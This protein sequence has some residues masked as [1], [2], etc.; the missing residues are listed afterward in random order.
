MAFI[1]LASKSSS[2]RHPPLARWLHLL[3]ITLCLAATGPHARAADFAITGIHTE[4]R[5]GVYVLDADID[6]HF[7]DEALR[8]LSNGVPLTVQ[9]S[10]EIERLRKWWLNEKI[11][12]LEQRYSL[13]HHALT[14]QYLLR[15]LNSGAFY[16]LPHYPAAVEAL[17]TLRDL[18]L[19]DAKLILPDERYQ[20]ALR[21]ELDIEALPSPLRPVAYITP[22]WHLQSDWYEW[23]LTP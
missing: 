21:V 9:L 13:Q 22:D 7:S 19:L 18:P 16:S 10:L 3:A 20:V 6:Y 8:A 5:E 23:F 2:R 4:I 17:G 11:A 12:T 1:T 15:N 14:H